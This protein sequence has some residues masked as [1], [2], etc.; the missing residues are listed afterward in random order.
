MNVALFGNRI[1]ISVISDSS[2]DK[3]SACNAGD[4]GLIPGS[5]RSPWEG[6]GNP[7]QWFCPENSTDRGA[8][9]AIIHGVARSWTRLR[10]HTHR[11]NQVKRRSNW[12]LEKGVREWAFKT[13]TALLTRSCGHLASRTERIHFCFKPPSLWCFVTAALGKPTQPISAYPPHR[14]V[15]K[16]KSGISHGKE[17]SFQKPQQLS[18]VSYPRVCLNQSWHPDV[19]ETNR[20][21]LPFKSQ[22]EFIERVFLPFPSLPPKKTP[23]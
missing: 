8:G 12:V 6:N 21:S 17:A 15:E 18:F 11:C 4:P 2:D 9:Q 16:D 3:E 22:G 23:T 13:S 14:G 20:L 19:L 5:G 7:F 1:P 10:T